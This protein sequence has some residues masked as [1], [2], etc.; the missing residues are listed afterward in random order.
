APFGDPLEARRV[1]ERYAILSA[2][3]A[4]G[5]SGAF[6][7]YLPDDL[8]PG[9]STG[10]EFGGAEALAMNRAGVNDAASSVICRGWFGGRKR[11]SSAFMGSNRRNRGM[12]LRQGTTFSRPGE[13]ETQSRLGSISFSLSNTMRAC[14]HSAS[15][16]VVGA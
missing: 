13:F 12:R 2:A 5:Q 6:A 11:V 3:S 7:D 10:G 16:S 8:R 4:G 9:I 1:R 14:G 15:C